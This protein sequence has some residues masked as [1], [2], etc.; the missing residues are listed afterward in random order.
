MQAKPYS[1][2]KNA[3][4]MVRLCNCFARSGYYVAVKLLEGLNN[5]QACSYE[6]ALI[7]TLSRKYIANLVVGTPRLMETFT[8]QELIN[9]GF[10]ILPQ[11][12]QK[13]YKQRWYVLPVRFV[14]Q[15]NKIKLLKTVL[16]KQSD[17]DYTIS[18]CFQHQAQ[19]T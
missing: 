8:N 17:C 2:C 14:L 10:D 4:L 3:E 16:I 15:R 19:K 18:K 11:T 7:T 13:G 9:P 12:L 5:D 6:T 1:G